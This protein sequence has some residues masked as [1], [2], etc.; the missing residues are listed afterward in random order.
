[1]LLLLTMLISD[2]TIAQIPVGEY[3]DFK[4]NLHLQKAQKS[5]FGFTA[6]GI[7]GSIVFSRTKK[8]STLAR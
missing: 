2:K 8:L 6:R 3:L 4:R 1:M 7:G 5:K